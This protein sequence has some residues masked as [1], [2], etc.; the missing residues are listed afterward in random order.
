[1]AA[2]A[3]S[4]QVKIADVDKTKSQRGGNKVTLT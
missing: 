2:G 3:S 1:M 4:N